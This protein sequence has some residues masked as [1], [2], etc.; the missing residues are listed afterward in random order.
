MPK[1]VFYTRVSSE[2]Q[3][4]R[5]FSLP[6]QRKALL[7]YVAQQGQDWEVVNEF[8]DEGVSA[9][10]PVE[11]RLGFM[12]MVSF[13]KKNRPDF[14]LVHRFCRFSRDQAES[15]HYKAELKARGV[16]VRSITEQVDPDTKEGFLY[17]RLIEVF[18]QYSS[19][20]LS[21]ETMKGMREKA[22]RGEVNG[23]PV[24]YGYKL[25]KIADARGREHNALGL[26]DED[27]IATVREIFDMNTHQGMGALSIANA[28]N[29]RKVPG[30]KGRRWTRPTVWFILSNRVYVGDLVWGKTKKVGRDG[31]A[32]TTPDEQIVVP[33]CFPAIIDR[34]TFEKRREVA[35]E[36]SFEDR[37]SRRQHVNYLLARIMRCGHCGASYCGRRQAY[38]TRKGVPR[39]RIAYY[40]GGYLSGGNAVCRS[41][42]I[43]RAWIEAQVVTAIRARL[44]DAEFQDR[45]RARI[46]ATHEETRRKYSGDSKALKQK[47]AGIDGQINNLLKALATGLELERVREMIEELNAKKARVEEE[48]ARIQQHEFAERNTASALATLDRMTRVVVDDFDQAPFAAQRQV[49]EAFVE[50]IEVRSHDH[51]HMRFM[52]PQDN[53]GL[54]LLVDGIEEALK[55]RSAD[56]S[57]ATGFSEEASDCRRGLGWLHEAQR[58]RTTWR[59][60]QGLR[61]FIVVALRT[62]GKAERNV[63]IESSAPS[64]PRTSVLARA[65]EWSA[66]IGRLPGVHNRA[67]LAAHL[68]VSR[69]RVTQALAPLAVGARL[70]AAMEDAEAQ[71]VLITN[72]LW[73]ELSGLPEREALAALEG[74]R[75]A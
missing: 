9:Y 75:A 37:K 22:S 16:R 31:R 51:V 70:L 4:K 32:P 55:A 21:F 41:R 72:K 23:G 25:V 11:K 43:D 49:I 1:V 56:E 53:G 30:P 13:A 48:A 60:D 69:A 62:C 36:R 58:S 15:I 45:I 12:E 34:E 68:G 10:G 35:K 73:R 18:N 65:R 19:M 57:D 59:V 2:D 64:R 67:D 54:K 63:G 38:S 7:A 20:S 33:D 40:C 3:A 17:E 29:A 8:T 42:P 74:L 14:I 5:D 6:A 46:R 28:L 39:E 24:P 44:S 52:V 26:G 66:L 71:G 50:T 47:I 27:E 61:V